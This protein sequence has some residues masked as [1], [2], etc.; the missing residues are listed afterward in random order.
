MQP[1]HFMIMDTDRDGEKELIGGDLHP[2]NK[3]FYLIVLVLKV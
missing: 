3:S 1:I 2:K